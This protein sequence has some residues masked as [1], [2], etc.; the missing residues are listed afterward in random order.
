MGA[1]S[2][3]HFLHSQIPPTVHGDLK[4]SNILVSSS[5]KVGRVTDYVLKLL[6]ADSYGSLHKDFVGKRGSNFLPCDQIHT[7]ISCVVGASQYVDPAAV[8]AG[9]F[10]WHSD[11]YR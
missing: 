6:Y 10:D 11:V 9:H 4:T 2:G 1:C 8:Q 3:L 5:K 7:F